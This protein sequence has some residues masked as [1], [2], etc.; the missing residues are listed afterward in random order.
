MKMKE[1]ELRGGGGGARPWDFP[2]YPCRLQR[3]SVELS[4]AELVWKY[5]KIKKFCTTVAIVWIFSHVLQPTPSKKVTVM[6][7][8]ITVNV[9]TARQT[10]RIEVLTKPLMEHV[11]LHGKSKTCKHETTSLQ[12]KTLMVCLTTWWCLFMI[13]KLPVK[14][15]MV[16]KKLNLLATYNCLQSVFFW[17]ALSR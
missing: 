8:H 4:A 14:K 1:I 13:F 15:V 5:V 6:Y 9:W 2:L 12:V 10:T 11:T 3:E 7:R 16:T 17:S